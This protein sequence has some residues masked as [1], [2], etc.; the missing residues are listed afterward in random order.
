MGSEYEKKKRDLTQQLLIVRDK[1]SVALQKSTTNL[2]RHRKQEGVKW[3]GGEHFNDIISIDKTNAIAEVEGMTTYEKFFNETLT[4][5][6][7]PAVVP[8]L[9]SITVGGAVT[10]GGIESSSFKE[11]LVHETITE[12]EILLSDGKTVACT[13]ENS[14]KD[15]FFGFPKF[16]WNFRV[17]TET[18][19]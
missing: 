16:L 1:G 6:L 7:R 10:G 18:K 9:K 5:G 17:R 19:S 14:Y 2:F 15:L 13:K 4:Q 12:M 11:G 3:I 8:Q